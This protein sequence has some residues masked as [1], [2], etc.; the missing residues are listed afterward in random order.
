MDIRKIFLFASIFL[1]VACGGNVKQQNTI[2]QE[3]SIII[4]SDTDIVEQIPQSQ[5]EKQEKNNASSLAGS[6]YNTQST[7]KYIFNEDYTG[8]FIM[9]S[10]GGNSLHFIWK[11]FG[12]KIVITLE[13]GYAPTTYEYDPTAET[14]IEH[15]ES[16]GT[17][18]YSKE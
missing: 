2:P 3:D 4:L 13:G 9:N 6:Y 17:L 14:L 10:T 15:S 18:I 12:N 16:F 5:I 1:L 8:T 11:R 7:D